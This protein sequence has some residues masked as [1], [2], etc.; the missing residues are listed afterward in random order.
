MFKEEDLELLNDEESWPSYPFMP[1]VKSSGK[2]TIYGFVVF[3]QEGAVVFL[4]N[5]FTFN[6][7]P[8]PLEELEKVSYS[9]FEVMLD[10]GWSID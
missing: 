6:R 2:K 1:M 3:G 8:S 10:D 7:H 4:K 9:S 5:L